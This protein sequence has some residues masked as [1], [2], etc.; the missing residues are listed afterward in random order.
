MLELRP[1]CE[2]CNKPLPPSSTEARIC[3]FECTFCADCVDELENV[4][5]NCGGG[6]EKRPV[7]PSV[8]LKKSPATE[9]VTHKP[10]DKE[11]HAKMKERY[12]HIPP[13]QR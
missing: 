4:C 11:K 9:K 1:T 10:V 7:R 5:P 2:N 13:H 6:F 3:T 8:P 12:Q